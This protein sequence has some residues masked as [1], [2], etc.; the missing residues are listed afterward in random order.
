M[1]VLQIVTLALAATASFAKPTKPHQPA[2]TPKVPGG[3]IQLGYLVHN[4]YALLDV[5]GP[6]QVLGFPAVKDLFNITYI[7]V[8]HDVGRKAY[9]SQTVVQTV[10]AGLLDAPTNLDL[11][12]IPGGG[13]RP[14]SNATIVQW[15]KN[16]VPTTPYFFSICTGASLLAAAGVL[17][18]KKATTN[19][20]AYSTVS[21]F[22][23]KTKWV[24]KA[25][26]VIDGNVVTSSGVAAG[27]DATFQVFD[28]VG[29]KKRGDTLGNFLEIIRAED[30]DDDPFTKFIDD[31]T[32]LPIIRGSNTT[33]TTPPSAPTPTHT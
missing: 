6:S 14:A 22:G 21:A 16:R 33:A 3:P 25:R 12:V 11:I 9:T 32:L 31:A 4:G 24:R 15:L 10:D 19:K 29:A 8:D 7:G 17:D 23:P 5:M 18:G 20:V 2:W 28:L 1:G 13:V 26:W 27:I 30:E